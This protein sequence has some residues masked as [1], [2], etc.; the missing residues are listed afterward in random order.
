MYICG[1]FREYQYRRHISNPVAQRW[2][3]ENT[4]ISGSCHIKHPAIQS[5]KALEPPL[6]P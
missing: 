1:S 6:N 5:S 3:L 2:Q 4:N